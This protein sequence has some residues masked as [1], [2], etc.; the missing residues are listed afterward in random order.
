MSEEINEKAEEQEEAVQK[1]NVREEN[2]ESKKTSGFGRT[3]KTYLD[4]GVETSMKGI[5]NAGAVISKFGDKSVIRI[6]I[7]RLKGRLEKKY[8]ELGECVAGQLMTEGETITKDSLAVSEKLASI[9]ELK[10]AIQ[11]KEDSLKQYGK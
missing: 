11:E 7:A 8:Q 3:I 5:K 1:E 9:R 6:D 4:K 10:D 2:A